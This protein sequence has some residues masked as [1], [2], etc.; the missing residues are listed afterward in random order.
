MDVII[1]QSQSSCYNGA[2]VQVGRRRRV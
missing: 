2:S 1:V